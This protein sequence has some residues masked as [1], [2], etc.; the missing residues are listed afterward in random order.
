M[1][2]QEDSYLLNKELIPSVETDVFKHHSDSR[3]WIGAVAVPGNVIM[4]DEFTA[5]RRLRANVYINECEFLPEGARE[6]DGGESDK[7]DP[8]ATQYV[9]FENQETIRVVGALRMIEK[10]YDLLPAEELF[11][12]EIDGEFPSNSLE[13]S[14]F[15]AR[16]QQRT[17]QT[18][19]S[20]GLVR[21]A[22]LQAL[23]EEKDIYAVVEEPLAR[24]FSQ[25]GLVYDVVCPGKVLA[26]YN[27]TNNQLLRFQPERILDTVKEDDL[28]TAYL[29]VA[30][31]DLGL[32]YYDTTLR[33][34][35]Y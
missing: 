5:Q 1:H 35:T 15:I 28:I 33:S 6:E 9:V 8:H 23:T 7:S 24:R 3:Y 16:H 17:A 22:I 27:N 10:G 20:V 12:D 2:N 19:I 4:P 30:H 11:A 26:E 18:M 31:Y 13:A 14:R 25:L 21:V 34:T 29:A 32:G